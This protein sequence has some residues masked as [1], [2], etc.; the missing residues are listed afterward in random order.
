MADTDRLSD[1]HRELIK[2][3]VDSVVGGVVGSE[4]VVA[5][6]EILDERVPGGDYPCGPAAFQSAHRPQPRLQSAMVG[7]DR[8]VRVPLDGMQCRGDQLIEDPR[9]G[10]GPVGG[11]LGRDGARRPQ[12]AGDLA[13]LVNRPVKVGPPGDLDVCLVGE[14][15]PIPGRM[16]AEPRRRDELRREPLH[17]PAHGEVVHGDAP[18]GQQLLDVPVGQAVTQAPADRDRD[19]LTRERKPANTE[20][21]PDD[22]IEPVCR[23]LRSANPTLPSRSLHC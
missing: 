20:D 6:A 21:P 9:I 4:F 14:P 16:P 15:A 18:L 7:F 1:G 8:V 17:P 10:R 5:A 19:D 2:C 12:R 11:D 13:M 22:A 3:L 23:Q